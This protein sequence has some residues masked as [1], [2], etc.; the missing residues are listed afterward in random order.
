VQE[1]IEG[2]G[3]GY[4]A[5]MNHGNFRA[6]FA[7]LRLRE[8]RPTG[9]GSSLRVSIKPSQKLRE[10]GR[11]MIN[12][13][14]GFHGAIMVEFKVRPDGT[15]VFLEV[16]PRLWN[17]LALAIYSGVNFPVLLAELAE[18]GDVSPVLD[19]KA[20]VRC[21]W[22]LGDL[23]HLVSV[24]K[25]KPK[26][27]PGK[28]PGRLRTLWDV[29]MPVPGTMHDPFSWSDPM[30]E[31]GDWIHSFK[32]YSDRLKHGGSRPT[33]QVGNKPRATTAA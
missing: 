1:F 2:Q 31:V 3:S 20:D 22:I 26:R 13:L 30:P 4:F 5:L 10:A 17:S 27:Y 18:R 19:Y 24:L 14:G 23:R 6:E 29:L 25:G 33:P 16:N 32:R 7:H 21:R 8:V 15:P 9:S 28:F 12:A 11:A